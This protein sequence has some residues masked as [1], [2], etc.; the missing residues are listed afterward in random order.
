MKPNWVIG[1]LF[2]CSIFN[3]ISCADVDWLDIFNH[4]AETNVGRKNGFEYS[5]PT[6]STPS[7]ELCGVVNPNGLDERFPVSREQ[8]RPGQFPW[9]VALF[10]NGKYFGGGSLISSGVVL[11]AAHLVMYK[12]PNSIVVRAGEWDLASRSGKFHFEERVVDKVEQH[13]H[14]SYGSSS[15]NIALLFLQ[16]PFELK[17]HIRT[18]CLPSQG[19]SVDEKRCMIAGWGKRAF[20]DIEIMKKQRL[21]ELPLISREE[22]QNKLRKTRLGEKYELPDSLICAG[23]EKDNDACT[24]DGGSAL[25]CPMEDDPARYAQAGIVNFGIGCAQENVPG[26]FTNVAMFR[27]FIDR[28][29]AGGDIDL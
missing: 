26:T 15:N 17:A 5:P 8:S 14:F 28:K 1:A 16:S 4:A 22:C 9:V 2:F 25:F 12:N 27:D 3:K 29:L 7:D 6:Q 11:T 24:G 13:E 23:G 18:I 19:K 10:S 20:E 21:I